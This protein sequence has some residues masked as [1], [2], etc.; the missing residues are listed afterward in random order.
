VAKQFDR[1]QDARARELKQLEDQVDKLRRLHERRTEARTEIV[2]DRVN[3]LLRQA[4]GLGWGAPEEVT[5]GP[6]GFQMGPGSIRFG[7][8]GVVSEDVRIEH[9]DH[10]VDSDHDVDVDEDED[11]DRDDDDQD[12]DEDPVRRPAAL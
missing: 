8:S 3:Q 10:D 11:Q 7:G 9:H 1:R 12:S 5:G 4:D 6:W 2:R